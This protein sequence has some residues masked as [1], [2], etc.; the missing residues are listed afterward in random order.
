MDKEQIREVLEKFTDG[1][2]FKLNP[3]K[4]HIDIILNGLIDNEKKHGLR[5]C[6]CRLRDGTKER[7]LELVCPCKFKT[8]KTW[9]EPNKGM[10]PM[11]SCGL[12]V[13]K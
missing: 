7:D 11:C 5:L 12:F 6:P 9:L 13:K 3:D 1:K 4:N 2:D 10:Q 8:H